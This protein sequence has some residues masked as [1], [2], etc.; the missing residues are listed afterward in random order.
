VP[1]ESPVSRESLVICARRTLRECRG[2]VNICRCV[3]RRSTVKC[4]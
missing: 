1:W 4:E 2:S 3:Q